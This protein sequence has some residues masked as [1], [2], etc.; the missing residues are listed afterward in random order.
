M[1]INVKIH[2]VK[3]IDDFEFDIPTEKWWRH[4]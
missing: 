3:D 1:G 4:R 2:N